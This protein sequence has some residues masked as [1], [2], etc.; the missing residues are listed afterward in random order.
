MILGAVPIITE[1]PEEVREEAEAARQVIVEYIVE[2]DDDLMERYLEGEEI[3]ADELRA[4]LRKATISGAATPVLCGTALRNKGIQRVLDAV[5][6]Y[7]PSP[8]DVPP[9]EG[10][11][12]YTEKPE[13]RKAADDEPLV[14]TGL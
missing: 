11:N 12:P 8:L 6:H 5:V 4:A 1:I 13:E 2:T 14:G 3:T 7:L 9:M 10:I